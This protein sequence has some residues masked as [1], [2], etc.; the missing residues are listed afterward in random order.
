MGKVFSALEKYEKERQ[1]QDS[2]PE[3]VDAEPTSIPVGA[4]AD[5]VDAITTEN[6]LDRD[7]AE[8]VLA[9][10]ATSETNRPSLEKEE[11]KATERMISKWSFGLR[12]FRKKS[13][14]GKAIREVKKESEAENLDLRKAET[15]EKKKAISLFAKIG[16]RV[17]RN[18]APGPESTVEEIHGVDPT[19]VALLKPHSFE[20]EQFKILRTNILFPAEG[21]PP[22]SIMVTSA[23]PGEGKSFVAANL[24][25]SIAQNINEHVLLMDCDIRRPCIQARFG[26]GDVPGLSEYLAEQTPLE[27]IFLKTQIEKLTI[28]PS[29]RPPHNPSEL[30]SSARMQQLL[31]ELKN[32]YSD[33]Y[34]IIDS[35][36]PKM[37]AETSA[38]ARYVDGIVVVVRFGK[39]PQHEVVDLMDSIGK[40]KVLGLIVNRFDVG[41]I[42]YG[43]YKQYDQYYAK[44]LEVKK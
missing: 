36:P 26:F 21:K 38:I 3:K 29:G 2:K 25:I 11:S 24:A 1:K 31:S 44:T 27:S 20:A 23:L 41:T 42:G 43:K 28:L 8:T 12:L 22:K 5:F 34:I 17:T 7:T 4:N 13:K 18:K 32:R 35:P 19:L 39:T 9:E 30:L 10:G 40:D 37:T 14:S 6:R 16:R 15:S 33:R